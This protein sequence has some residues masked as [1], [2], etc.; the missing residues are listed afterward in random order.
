MAA[1][2]PSVS[3]IVPA[4]NRAQL[5]LPTLRS[6]ARQTW[7]P[8]DVV[9][10][11]DGSTDDTV[12][13]VERF[14]RHFEARGIGCTIGRHAGGANRGVSATRN[15]AFEAA[16]GE[17]V[18]LLD[19][20]D[21]LPA[22]KI[23]CH[24]RALA[25]APELDGVYCKAYTFRRFAGVP[26]LAPL[27]TLDAP[28]LRAELCHRSTLAPHGPLFRRRAFELAG[29][30]DPALRNGEDHYFWWRATVGGARF[31]LESGRGAIR[32]HYRRHGG[33]IS[34]DLARQFRGDAVV[35]RRIGAWAL[36]EGR[37]WEVLG[38][39]SGL[40]EI[41]RELAALA[42]PDEAEACVAA[43]APLV[44]RLERF[45]PEDWRA[46]WERFWISSVQNLARAPRL[47][48]D[49]LGRFA[50]WA[51]RVRGPRELGRGRGRTAL[52]ALEALA[53]APG[54]RWARAVLWRAAYFRSIGIANALRLGAPR[55]LAVGLGRAACEDVVSGVERLRRLVR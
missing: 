53:E 28:D 49:V 40:A 9:V 38:A 41:G 36:A 23:A 6:V 1:A 45:P 35:R 15:A 30:F 29:G 16:R 22:A 42:I 31:R 11:D 10:W 52:S 25:A 34:G 12:R 54:E 27:W 47:A 7:R 50:R 37:G 5:I 43:I 8:L 18:Q 24:A 3:V 4:W 20:D 26:W 46:D 51:T 44:E 39:I 55:A 2:R 17:L 21:L 32:V 14:A 48:D 13:V 19:S 33:N